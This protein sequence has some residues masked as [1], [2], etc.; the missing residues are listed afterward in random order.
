MI[1]K[2][3]DSRASGWDNGWGNVGIIPAVTVPEDTA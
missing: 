1:Q 3:N 2:F